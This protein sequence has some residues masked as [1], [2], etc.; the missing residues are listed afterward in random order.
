MAPALP[1][2]P[3]HDI[4]LTLSKAKGDGSMHSRRVPRSRDF[5][6]LG[7]EKLR[8]LSAKIRQGIW[9]ASSVRVVSG[10][11]FR[12]TASGTSSIAPLGA[13]DPGSGLQASCHPTPSDAP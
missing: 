3:P 12:R 2:S 13:G 7:N 6:D 11:A 8:Y 1:M 9:R 4:S 5:R 10:Y